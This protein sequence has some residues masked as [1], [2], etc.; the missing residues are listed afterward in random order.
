MKNI[1]QI[2]AGD[3]TRDYSKVFLHYGVMLIGS[4]EDGDY[5]KHKRQYDHR[6][7]RYFAEEAV[8]GDLVVLTR[9]RERNKWEAVAVGKITSEYLYV[10]AFSDVEGFSLQHCRQVEWKEPS[11]LRPVRGLAWFGG[12]ICHLNNPQ[13]VA[14]AKQIWEEGTPKKS[15]P[16]PD[17]PEELSPKELNDLLAAKRLP[18]KRAECIVKKIEDLQRLADWY[19]DVDLYDEVSEDEAR[20]FLVVPFVKSLGWDEKQMRI[21]WEHRDVVLFDSQY[22]RKRKQELLILIETKRLGDGLGDA[23]ERQ[24]ADYAKKN[25]T[26]DR[27]VVTDGIRYKMF[28]KPTP[29]GGWIFSHYLNVW[30]PTQAHPYEPK[31][32]GAVSFLLKML[33]RGAM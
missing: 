12:T 5:R 20:T 23:P 19:Y 26:C 16:I 22:P 3:S 29:F 33:P 25:P 31:V 17:E 9:A 1:W 13:A 6:E 15:E 27:L 14:R 30:T 7:Y 11:H 32:A 21:E 8:K 28:T 2:K 10:P 4:G 18:R 24:A